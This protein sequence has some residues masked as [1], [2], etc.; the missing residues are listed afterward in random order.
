[1]VLHEQHDVNP[2]VIVLVFLEH[3]FQSGT[4][5]LGVHTEGCETLVFGLFSA[6]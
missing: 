6:K 1:V 5:L 4:I 3:K 2:L